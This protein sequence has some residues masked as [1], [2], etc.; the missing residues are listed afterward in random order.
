MARADAHH[1]CHSPQK[2]IMENLKIE[3]SNGSGKYGQ[4]FYYVR[5][6]G[7]C[8]NRSMRFAADKLDTG[9][10]THFPNVNYYM[11]QGLTIAAKNESFAIKEYRR[12]C[13]LKDIG[14]KVDVVFSHSG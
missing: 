7:K 8:S 3:R 14:K 11:I 1:F 9:I 4:V 6:A 10:K 12:I 13:D 5:P 2:I